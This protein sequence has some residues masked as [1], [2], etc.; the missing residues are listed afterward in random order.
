MKKLIFDSVISVLCG[1]AG[2]EFIGCYSITCDRLWLV[3]SFLCFVCSA[4]GAFSAVNLV[5][6]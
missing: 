3:F 2:L 4:I 6:R 1:F 5:R